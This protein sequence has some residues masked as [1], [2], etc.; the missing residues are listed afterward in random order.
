MVI[1][2]YRTSGLLKIESIKLCKMIKF[3]WRAWQLFHLL[4]VLLLLVLLLLALV[5]MHLSLDGPKVGT[6]LGMT[7]G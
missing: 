6:S 4:L 1:V 3:R 7:G 5:R 2:C